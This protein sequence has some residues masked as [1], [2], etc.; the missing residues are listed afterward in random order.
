MS[1]TPPEKPDASKAKPEDDGLQPQLP[2]WMLRTFVILEGILGLLLQAMLAFVL[3]RIFVAIVV[4]LVS[5]Q[6]W[7]RTFGRDLLAVGRGISECWI[8]MVV[9]SLALFYGPIRRFLEKLHKAGPLET[10]PEQPT[11]EADV[12][13]KPRK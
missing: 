8:A 6:T 3:L 11:K 5:D 2:L 9:A 1:S 13:W 10:H 7:P 12:D 4:D